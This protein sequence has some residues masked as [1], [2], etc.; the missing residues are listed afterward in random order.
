MPG[1]EQG[2]FVPASQEAPRAPRP[3]PSRHQPQR[4]APP[5]RTLRGTHAAVAEEPLRVG[6]RGSVR[7]LRVGFHE[8]LKV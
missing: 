6:E 8:P 7:V 1:Q 2:R 5:A 3:R 4:R